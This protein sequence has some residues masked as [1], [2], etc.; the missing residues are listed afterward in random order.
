MA[1]IVYV[2]YAVAVNIN[3]DAYGR[4]LDIA[5]S[6][7]SGLGVVGLS[8]SLASILAKY[9]RRWLAWIGLVLSVLLMGIDFYLMLG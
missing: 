3:L 8:V 4:A 1:I 5:I 2:F 6:V 7:L 9:K